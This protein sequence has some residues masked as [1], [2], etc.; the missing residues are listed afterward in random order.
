[1][2]A[3]AAPPAPAGGRRRPAGRRPAPLGTGPRRTAGLLVLA[4]LVLVAAAASLAIG[5]VGIPPREVLDALLAPDGSD[6]QVIV[7]ELRVPRTVVAIAVGVAL[8]ASGAIVQGLTRNPIGDPGVLG[9]N[10]GAALAVVLA[11]FAFGVTSPAAYVWFALAGGLATAAVVYALG[12]SGRDGA[13]PVKLALAGAVTGSLLAS[14]TYTVLVL[15]VETLDRFRFW[16]VGSVAGRDLEVLAGTLPLLGVGLLLAAVSGRWLNA[17]AL[18]DDLARTLGLRVGLVRGLCGLGAVALAAA[19]V[20]AA[21][22]IA[23]VGLVAPHLARGLVGPD[24]RWVV[25]CSALLGALVLLVADVAGRVVARPGE[26]EVGI[27]A[28]FVG[29]PVFIA[30]VRRRKLAEL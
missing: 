25:P 12:S 15:D 22:P 19:A 13:T 27:V 28:A 9:I 14:L 16:V 3:T 24:N 21:G 2:S 23:F 11:I 30:L 5:S 10:S 1:V 29:A 17:L 18:G 20:A 7:T 4:V 26:V 6:A 8:G